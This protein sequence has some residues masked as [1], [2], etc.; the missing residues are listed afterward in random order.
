MRSS[1]TNRSNGTIGSKTTDEQKRQS[2]RWN[3]NGDMPWSAPIY[4][5]SNDHL[6]Y[7]LKNHPPILYV[8]T[9]LL[10]WLKNQYD[11]CNMHGYICTFKKL[12]QIADM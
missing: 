6:V 3:F 7:R 11:V 4:V 8:G 12:E 5:L 2:N 1:A 9:M 10:T